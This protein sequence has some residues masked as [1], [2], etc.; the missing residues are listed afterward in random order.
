M[1]ALVKRPAGPA[2]ESW[3]RPRVARDDD[4][5]IRAELAG[6]CRTD[7]FVADGAIVVAEP[8]IIGHEVAGVLEEA[9]AGV[10]LPAG[11]RVSI[12]PLLGCGR[13]AGCHAGGAC[14]T[15]EFL[16]ID[17][18]G[19]FADWL[20]VPRSALIPLPA[21][22]S[23]LAGAFLEPVAAALAVLRAGILPTERGLVIGEPRLSVLAAR[24]L[25][26]RG[27]TQVEVCDAALAADLPANHFDYIIETQ[28]TSELFA[29]YLAALRPAGKLILKSR[30]PQRVEFIPAQLVR[31]EPVIVPVHYGSFDEAL[32][33]LAT[34]RVQVDD[35]VGEC[36]PLE[37]FEQALA[38]ARSGAAGK[39]FFSW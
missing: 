26:A 11:T 18:H 5:V 4:V 27:F 28:L 15:P 19:A 36:Y 39:Q 17:R 31:K 34:G 25:D 9:G 20:V 2:L 24:V 3:A 37:S 38:A 6:L 8:R 14:T 10:E 32:E 22:V 7:V 29:C 30:L 13:C 12:C 21:T 16:G 33:L 1:R 23:A 35:L